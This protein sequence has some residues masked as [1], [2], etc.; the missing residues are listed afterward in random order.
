MNHLESSAKVLSPDRKYV[1]EALP[2]QTVRDVLRQLPEW[3]D[4]SSLAVFNHGHRIKDYDGFV[5]NA[6]D[7]LLICLVPEGGGGGGGGK[8]IL[9]VVAAV[10]IIAVAWWN[11][12]GWAA[13]GTLASQ[14][15]LYAVGGSLLLGGVGTMIAPKPELGTSNYGS[16]Q[17][18][19]ENAYFITGQ[20][21]AAK[22]Y[23]PVLVAY[24]KNKMFPVLAAN[25]NIINVGNESTFDALYDFGI[26]EQSYDLSQIK[27]GET[28]ASQYSPTYYQHTN[29]KTPDLKLITNRYSYQE[30]S[31]AM[32]Q[33][34]PFTAQT[35][36]QTINAEVNITFPRGLSYI[37]NEGTTQSA[38]A[39]LAVYWSPA[40]AESWTAI[41][42]KDFQG[43]TVN[44]TGSTA[45]P[46][47]FGSIVGV[48]DGRYYEVGPV[49]YQLDGRT[50]KDV[51]QTA[52][53]LNGVNYPSVV[54][55]EWQNVYYQGSPDENGNYSGGYSVEDWVY[56]QIVLLS[57]S[58]LW[59]NGSSQPSPPNGFIWNS[60]YTAAVPSWPYNEVVVSGATTAPFVLIAGIVFPNA[61]TYDVRV[62]RWSPV[63]TDNR[64]QDATVFTMLESRVVGNVLNLSAP[65]TMLEM[66]VKASD[67][68]NGVVQNLSVITTSV[69]NIYNASGQVVSRSPSRNPAW[70]AI[71]ILT[72]PSNPRPIRLDQVDWPAWKA[73][74]DICD[75][76]R[77]WTINGKQ[78]TTARF[79]CDTVIDYSTTVKQLL[80]G[81]LSTC[82]SSLV[83]GLNGRY[84]VM[85]DGER[86][87]P[88]QLITPSNSWDFQASRQFPAD[89]QAL[90]VSF[91]D[92]ASDYQK[93]ELMVY[94]DGYNADNTENV[95]DLGTFGVTT[96]NHAW[97]F[98]RY[99]MAAAINRA[100]VFTVNMDVENLACQ[101]GDLVHVAHDVPLVGGMPCRVVTVYGNTVE[102]TEEFSSAANSYT[103]RL[104]DGTIRQGSVTSIVDENTY[105]LDNSN[106]IAPGDLIVL[107]ESQRVVKAYIVASISPSNDL[108]AS[109][110][111]LP[112]IKEVYDADIGK[113][114]EWNPEIS[115]DL[116][117]S[118]NLRVTSITSSGQSFEYID[119][120]PHAKFK[121]NWTIND[122]RFLSYYDLRITTADGE[123]QLVTGLV[124]PY[125]EYSIDVAR[126]PQKLGIV[127]FEA[128]PYT[129]GGIP[130]TGMSTID[131]ITPDRIRPATVNWFLV[132]VQDMN[133]ALSWEPPPEPDILEYELRY[134][135][136]VVGAQWNASQL[137]GKFPY[138]VTRTMVGARTGTYGILVRDTSGNVSDISGKRSTIE[139]L[140]NIN[141]VDT[142]NDAPL[143]N[144]TLGGIVLEGGSPTSAGDWGSVAPE[145][146]YYYSTIFDAGFVYELRISSKIQSHGT[147]FED[148]MVNWIPLASAIPLARAQ[149]SLFNTMLEVR[150]ANDAYF[151]KDWM[152][153]SSAIPIGG[154]SPDAWSVW[155]PCE[156][157][158]FTG[159]LFQFRIRMESFDPYV[160][161]V[162]DDGMIE[163]DVRDRI[164]RFNDLTVT[165]TGLTVQF[166]PAFMEPPT[167]AI[168]TENS[169]AVRYEISNKTRTSFDIDL[170][171]ELGKPVSGQIDVLALGYGREK[172]TRI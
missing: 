71:D 167:L 149:S 119:R 75:T 139:T 17:R 28:L 144:G 42:A 140:P 12:M 14:A 62:V 8:G 97:A 46:C 52:I 121:I 80:E 37:S 11:P 131:V 114:P 57:P 19:A 163:I 20:S 166:D 162:V 128:I 86:V 172:P 58:Q 48:Q 99:Q 55:Y 136:L 53:N 110:S 95:E 132:N 92:E 66:R 93:Q 130:G 18:D 34:I 150:T 31:I 105:T 32:E 64:R 133:I 73:L 101:R 35:K 63:S 3:H 50:V 23:Q 78:V 145:G 7:N 125:Y 91:I 151:M 123:T 115:N 165:T 104:A 168:T 137:I 117:N 77:T 142:I 155:R 33:Y 106:G 96:F 85:F 143:W 22:P 84:S 70:I 9:S 170:F 44:Q 109:L 2:G 118:T 59:I 164:D 13:A 138:N 89:V 65:H 90:R 157:G 81:V 72:G 156:V 126:N 152:P 116:I 111:L 6:G 68:L 129:A 127:T 147:R 76:P 41:R 60:A 154:A 108:T 146:F 40:G 79:M 38:T 169:Q 43:A 122:P 21:N 1:C 112:Y 134:S 67:K 103:V 10:A 120:Y 135:P 102:V 98:A 113:L 124:K 5:V 47:I 94:R 87:I 36:D 27:F 171:D 26:G 30:F 153:L 56:K 16:S 82:R 141:L 161:A 45:T 49:D 61:G 74:A 69:L 107:G 15:T 39:T 148:L 159:R 88:R 160:K 158:D 29:T 24:G 4:H 83:I 54:F 100:E 25:P 51:T